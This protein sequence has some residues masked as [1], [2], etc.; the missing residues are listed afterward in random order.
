M[1]PTIKHNALNII[2][3]KYTKQYVT[4]LK[5]ELGRSLIIMETSIP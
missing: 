1:R 3:L 4:K 2:I 5:K